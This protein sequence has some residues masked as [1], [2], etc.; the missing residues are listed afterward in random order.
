MTTSLAIVAALV[1]FAVL[2]RGKA[3]SQLQAPPTSRPL[4]GSRP[5]PKQASERPAP[6]EPER[7][8]RRPSAG[9]AA[10]AG[11]TDDTRGVSARRPPGSPEAAKP[12]AAPPAASVP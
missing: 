11:P 1:V 3:G 9:P 2:A 4:P 5:P 6:R 7:A 8:D 12:S 10:S